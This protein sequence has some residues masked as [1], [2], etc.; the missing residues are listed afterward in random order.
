[1][2]GTAYRQTI[3]PVTAEG[4]SRRTGD[5]EIPQPA[6]GNAASGPFAHFGA[7]DSTAIGAPHDM[8]ALVGMSHVVTAGLPLSHESRVSRHRRFWGRKPQNAEP[9]CKL[10]AVSRRPTTLRLDGR[11]NG[12]DSSG[13]SFRRASEHRYNASMETDPKPRNRWQLRSLGQFLVLILLL[14]WAASTPLVVYRKELFAISAHFG[15]YVDAPY[16][17][18]AIAWPA[19]AI[20]SFIALEA[21]LWRNALGKLLRRWFRFGVRTMLCVLFV[22][23]ALLGWWVNK[24]LEQRR[25]IAEI[26]NVGGWVLYDFQEA[27]SIP[28]RPK[29][30]RE[31]FGDDLFAD[32]A[33][34]TLAGYIDK[35][36][37]RASD[38]TLEQ[39]AR[40]TA[41]QSLSIDSEAI[42]DKGLES[43]ASLKSL[44]ELEIDS[45]PIT[46]KGL[47]AI[48]NLKSLRELE[49]DSCPITDAGLAAIAQL[50]NLR[51]LTLY[52]L[53][54]TNAGIAHLRGLTNLES[55]TLTETSVSKDGI[56]NLQR[57]L[58]HCEISEY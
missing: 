15:G 2:I 47:R 40:L 55:L 18:R 25:A 29:W 33:S 43:I 3:R 17:N 36:K 20:V 6:P 27:M 12:D 57:L 50:T 14:G 21:F 31:R 1:V 7:G 44:R 35:P 51:S 28:L 16:L 39:V 37:T 10:S 34:V 52:S 11:P 56:A 46:D 5:D 9:S 22:V 41:L 42:T 24:A 8:L 38:A 58:P 48:A 13:L 45:C 30:V 26:R 54:I 19:L 4:R 49:I 32:A 53:P 23:S